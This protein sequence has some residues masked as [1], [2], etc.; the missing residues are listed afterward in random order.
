MQ[1]SNSHDVKRSLLLG[2]GTGVLLALVFAAGFFAR[3]VIP[4]PS[5]VPPSANG[6]PLL[7]EVQGLV[8]RH[9][10]RSQPDYMERQYAAIR[11]MLSSLGD[12]FTFFID[13]P[14]AASESDALAG[15]YGGIGVQ[16]RRN[17]QGEIQLFPYES[18]PAL[19]AGI[20]NGDILRAV[21]GASL[22]PALGQDQIDQM[23]RGEVKPESGVEITVERSADNS[24]FTVF[25]PFEVINVPSVI[26]RVLDDAPE[27]GYVQITSFTGRTPGE[28]REA[29]EALQGEQ[30]QALILD[31]RNNTGGLL[32]ES[33]QVANAFIGNGA[34][35]YEVDN[36]REQVYNAQPDQLITD[37]PLVVLVNNMTASGAELVAGAIQDD[38]RG[39]LIGQKTYGKGTV[40]QIF[41]LSDQSS[42][43]VTSAEWLTPRRNALDS[44]GLQP[45]ISMIPDAQGRDV[46]LGEAVR[47]LRE[48]LGQVEIA[49][50]S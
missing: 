3:D 16:I 21:N 32:Q 28:L 25:I 42:L 27:I 19:R 9:F 30:V 48:Q 26:W 23:L 13:P 4:L 45:D 37:L 17:E 10:L 2:L 36:Q 47:N 33:I 43:H 41:P 8:D 7:D 15:T 44:V 46:E 22:D 49:A 40:Q 24:L 34:L 35:V 29:V 6:Y 12:R 38:G 20:E 11:G 18:G 14:V 50:G 1:K 31:L 39:V 5:I